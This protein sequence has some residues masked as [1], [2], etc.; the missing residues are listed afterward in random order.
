MTIET[1]RRGFLRLLGLA[2]IAVPLAA[3]LIAVEEAQASSAAPADAPPCVYEH[4][5]A[6][7][8]SICHTHGLDAASVPQHH[9]HTYPGV[10]WCRTHGFDCPSLGR[11]LI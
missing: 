11:V 9:H 8:S 4:R 6:R 5:P 1:D 10:A 3:P 2:P 7:D